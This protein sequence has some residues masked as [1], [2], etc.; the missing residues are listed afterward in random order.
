[1]KKRWFWAII[2]VILV[3]ISFL[4]DVQ[5]IKFIESLRNFFLDYILISVA[6]ASNVL[7]IL[8]FL[9]VLLLWKKGKRRWI[10]P[11]WL[12]IFLS[13]II[14][15]LIKIAVQRSRPFQEGVVS[16]LNVVF[17]FLKDSFYTWNYSF[18][19]FQAMLVF[20]ALPVLSKEFRR[21]RYIWL[22]F[23]CATAF[24]RIYFGAHYLSDVLVG[25]I[26]GYLIGYIMV[27]VEERYEIGLKLSRKIKRV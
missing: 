21:F 5:I 16:I 18:P 2:L 25:A 7:I 3:V 27:R 19:S 14:S 24:A 12:S 20:S 13:L 6:F 4:F 23:A 26:I 22:I 1:M 10:F 17:Y 11:L 9:T 15:F 8:L